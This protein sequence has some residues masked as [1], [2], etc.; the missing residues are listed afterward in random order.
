MYAP[1]GAFFVV[2]GSSM[3]YNQLGDV[4]MNDKINLI[5][6]FIDLKINE[7]LP[8]FRN[9]YSEEY[10][11]I[12]EVIRLFDKIQHRFVGKTVTE[13][14]LYI[15]TAIIAL[16]KLFQ[17]AVVLFERGLLESGNAIIR[18]CLESSFKIVELVNNKNFVDDMK[19]ELA[20]ETRSTLNIIK[21]KGLFHIVPQEELDVLLN[22]V[23]YAGPKFKINAS[24]LAEKNGL[25]DAY[26]LYRLYCNENHQSIAALREIQTFQDDQVHLNGNLRL[27][28]FSKAIYM[29]ISVAIIPF[30]ALIDMLS[31]YVELKEQYEAF[32]EKYQHTFEKENT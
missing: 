9:K 1:E 19:R 6:G 11:L 32:V 5:D 26:I 3:C 31:D 8:Q 24:Q 16:N 29:L 27:E 25:L 28:E 23:E 17:S 13:N 10:E 12:R 2:R 22:K 7:Q 21:T 15:A 18:V 4:N 14:E 30:P 20:S